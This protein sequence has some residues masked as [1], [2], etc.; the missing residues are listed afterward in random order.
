MQEYT[1]GLKIMAGQQLMSVQSN[2]MN[3]QKL[4]L[5]VMLTGYSHSHSWKEKQPNPYL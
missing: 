5:P 2:E 3:G 4:H 1:S